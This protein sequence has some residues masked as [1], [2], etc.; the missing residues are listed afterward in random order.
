MAQRSGGVVVKIKAKS[1]RSNIQ[2]LPGE[3][4]RRESA[5]EM[6][7]GWYDTEGGQGNGNCSWSASGEVLITFFKKRGDD[8]N[9]RLRSVCR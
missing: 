7:H 6:P 4:R 8:A 2:S 9:E 5:K 1:G 3:D